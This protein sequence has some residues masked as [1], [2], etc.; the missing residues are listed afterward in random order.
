MN[1]LVTPAA[2]TACIVAAVSRLPEERVSLAAGIGR[3]LRAALIADRPLPPYRR[4]TMD[5]L[6]FRFTSA[7]S[8]RIVGLHAAGDP[9]PRLLAAGEAW[10]IMTG[11]QVPA[12]CDTLMPYEEVTIRDGIARI[13]GPQVPGRFIHEVGTD[14]EL[15]K[16]LV[17]PG[18]V[19]GPVEIAIAAS[20][21]VRE[22]VVS[23][24]P[25]ITLLTTGDEAVP[26]SASPQPWQIRRSNGPM[27]EAMLRSSG[28]T[29]IFSQHIIDDEDLLGHAV[30][31]AISNSDLIILCGGISKGRRDHVRSVLE[32]RL[33]A[34]AFHGVCQRPGKPLA[35]WSGP[36][37]VF[38]L[39]GNPVSV[40]A[41]FVHYVL[42]TL[43]RMQGSEPVPRLQLR[44]ASALD[45][46]PT[47]TWLLP[48]RINV[49]GEAIALPPQNS[50]DFVSVAGATHL[51]EIPPGPATLPSGTAVSASP[52]RI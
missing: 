5:G 31:A 15:G 22:L 42:P 41:T 47:L 11:A 18:S 13:S 24:R 7:D 48:C 36:P 40:L 9:P 3:V 2:A 27:L 39:P 19:L 17:M 29:D 51:L 49:Q 34:P 38:A 21:G 14:A 23:R 6:A 50:G 44:L 16:I 28:I 10:E 8:V 4:A 45:P 52:F 33:G 32:A 25:A 37:Q 46:H 20:I 30:E 1:D 12:D 43:S 35:F 26:V